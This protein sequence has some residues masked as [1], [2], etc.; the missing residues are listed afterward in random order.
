MKTYYILFL[1]IVIN[2]P[3]SSAQIIEDSVTYLN[4]IKTELQKKWP[5]NR[6]INLVFHGHSVPS[7]Y[8]KTP[9]VNT[10]DSYPYLTLKN[11]K[12]VYPH[13]VV[14][15]ITTSIGGEQSEQGAERFK[16]DVLSHRPDVLFIDYALNDRRIGLKSAK[17]AWEKMIQEAIAYGTKVILL[18]PTPDLNEDINSPNSELAK[19]SSQI[20][21]LAKKYKIGLVDSYMLFQEIAKTEDLNTYMAQGNHINKRGHQVVAKAILDLFSSESK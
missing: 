10:L 7:G 18:T 8:F 4:P 1:L 16:E 17:E 21:Q 20:R 19:H 13:A 3:R 5:A 9:H 15:S 14:N 6:T 12:D 11:V 2:S